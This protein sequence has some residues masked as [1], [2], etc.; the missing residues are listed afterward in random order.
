[1][2]HQTDLKFIY[3]CKIINELQI[4]DT[5]YPNMD[6]IYGDFKTHSPPKSPHIA[7]KDVRYLSKYNS[8]ICYQGPYGVY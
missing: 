3:L 4:D 7:L 5:A 6:A 8:K 2:L 1:M